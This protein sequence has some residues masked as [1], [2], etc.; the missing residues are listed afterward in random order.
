MHALHSSLEWRTYTLLNTAHW[1][2]Q[3]TLLHPPQPPDYLSVI[4]NFLFPENT[5]QLLSCFVLVE[6][7][8]S[9]GKEWPQWDLANN[10]LPL[11][12]PLRLQ[13]TRK[14]PKLG[15][16]TTIEIPQ[17]HRSVNYVSLILSEILHLYQKNK[18]PNKTKNTKRKN[19]HINFSPYRFKIASS[20]ESCCCC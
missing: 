15:K 3:T 13:L 16:P 18:K 20:I 1:F 8:Q 11:V 14:K 9:A 6:S 10:L 12:P 4:T 7:S 5:H 2:R 17:G 19:L